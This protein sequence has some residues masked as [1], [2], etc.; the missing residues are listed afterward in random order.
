[1]ESFRKSSS[2]TQTDI[3]A[4]RKKKEVLE[5]TTTTTNNNNNNNNDAKYTGQYKKHAA[6]HKP[7][8]KHKPKS[9]NNEQSNQGESRSDRSASPDNSSTSG[10][11]SPSAG[12]HSKES[13]PCGSKIPS[14]PHSL[15]QTTND[16]SPD[17]YDFT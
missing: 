1:M 2:G 6:P 8:R 3:S 4:I 5:S 17:R 11:S 15:E 10:Y 13:S 7:A 14:P 12:L 16:E 9:N